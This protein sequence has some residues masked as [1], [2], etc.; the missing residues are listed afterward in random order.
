M[1]LSKSHRH[2][3]GR[4]DSRKD[5]GGR[6]PTTAIMKKKKTYQSQQCKPA[7][8]QRSHS[9]GEYQRVVPGRT[10]EWMGLDLP[11]RRKQRRNQL[12]AE[13]RAGLAVVIISENEKNEPGV[14][15]DP[16]EWWIATLCCGL[17][18]PGW[19]AA[20]WKREEESRS[21]ER[22]TKEDEPPP[23][24]VTTAAAAVPTGRF[25]RG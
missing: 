9:P 22:E 5:D 10:T 13:K 25:R 15:S 2:P 12:T 20:L 21:L 19:F 4:D 1:R 17:L 14:Y 16:W 6:E 18:V 7:N 23:A 11:K 8:G 3:D 24:P